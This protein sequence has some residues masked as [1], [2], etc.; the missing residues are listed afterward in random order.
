MAQLATLSVFD[1]QAT[2]VAHVFAPANHSASDFI[3]RET[4][5]SSVL[6][7]MVL[8]LSK[9]PM[10]KGS[11]LEKS[12]VK[13]VM[14]VLETIT[15]SNSS[16]YTAAPRLAYTLQSIVDFITPTRATSSQRTDLVKF[17]RQFITESGYPQISD[18]TIGS[19]WPY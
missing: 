16:G 19:S 8:T 12:R 18:A 6:N 2:P 13:L 11:D 1:S 7:A 5:T 3:W 10:K 17:T 4:G 14:P 15:G 9:L